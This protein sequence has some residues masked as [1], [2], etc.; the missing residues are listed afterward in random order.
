M[1]VYR[2][3]DR[4][5]AFYAA[6]GFLNR[7]NLQSGTRLATKLSFMAGLLAKG[8]A[9]N[10]TGDFRSVR[11]SLGGAVA[12]RQ[13]IWAL[14][15][16]M[17]LDPQ[18]GPGS[19]VIPKLENAATLRLFATQVAEDKGGLRDPTRQQ[20][21]VTPSALK[22]FQD[23]DL[24]PP[25][26]KY[27]RGTGVTAEERIKLVWDAIGTDFGGRYELYERT[28]QAITSKYA[29]TSRTLQRYA[30]SCRSTPTWPKS[31]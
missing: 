18:P 27:Y 28:T 19:T 12:W 21:L 15:I 14:T 2:D 22:D 31:A 25:I 7:Y 6:S 24:R 23:S 4:A 11:V 30:A 5:R 20:P 13:L 29:S 26:D 16:A 8:I 17:A 9:A 1:L 3:V 10:G